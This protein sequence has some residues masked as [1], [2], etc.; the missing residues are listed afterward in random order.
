M[1]MKKKKTITR[2]K[3]EW[4][5]GKFSF[6]KKIKNEIL[7]WKYGNFVTKTLESMQPEYSHTIFNFSHSCEIFTQKNLWLIRYSHK[8][9]VCEAIG[10]FSNPNVYH[11]FM[12]LSIPLLNRVSFPFFCCWPCLLLPRQK[13]ILC[14]D[15]LYRVYSSLKGFFIGP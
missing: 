7:F 10:W 6:P 14:L 3:P 13:R 12:S 11:P 9:E 5:C 1:Q 15:S 4:K 8:C 2:L